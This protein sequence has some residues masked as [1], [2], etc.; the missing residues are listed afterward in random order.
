MYIT[1]NVTKTDNKNEGDGGNAQQIQNTGDGF[2]ENGQDIDTVS[3]SNAIAAIAIE[4]NKKSARV[5][6]TTSTNVT[7][8]T[9]SKTTENESFTN[10]TFAASWMNFEE[11][12]KSVDNFNPGGGHFVLTKCSKSLIRKMNEYHKHLFKMEDGQRTVDK[13]IMDCFEKF[14]AKKLDGIIYE[15]YRIFFKKAAAATADIFN[16]LSKEPDRKQFENHLRKSL[17]RNL[18]TYASKEEAEDAYNYPYE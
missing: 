15:F 18:P 1:Q 17:Q 14:I 4:S 16:F 2:E 8:T 3:A 7:P 6:S 12:K 13:V 11:F 10:V 5:T 9:S